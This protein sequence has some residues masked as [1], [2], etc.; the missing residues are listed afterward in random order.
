MSSCS[1]SEPAVIWLT[2]RHN[3]PHS[4]TRARGEAGGTGLPASTSF[5]A[6]RLPAASA[7][8]SNR[9]PARSSAAIAATWDASRPAVRRPDAASAEQRR[10]PSGAETSDAPAVDE[11]VPLPPLA[12]ANGRGGFA[13]GGRAYAI[14]LEGDEETPAPWANVIANPDFGTIVTAS[15]SSHTWAEQQPREPAD[16]VCQRPGGRSDR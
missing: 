15:G 14:V 1:T 13:D 10:W 4:S 5:A 8:C 16:L 11:P 12:L 2:C 7:C 6:T 3:S 9:S